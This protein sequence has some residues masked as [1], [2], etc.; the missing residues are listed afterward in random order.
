MAAAVACCRGE[1]PLTF[2]AAST[3][4]ALLFCTPPAVS[5]RAGF[6][7]LAG[8]PAHLLAGRPGPIVVTQLPGA[9]ATSG[10]RWVADRLGSARGWAQ[11][12]SLAVASA[13]GRC[14][15]VNY[16][17]TSAGHRATLP[18]HRHSQR[19][20][21][22]HRA[23]H[24]AIASSQSTQLPSQHRGRTA[25]ALPSH[26]A[27][28]QRLPLHCRSCRHSTEAALP[29]RLPCSDCRRYLVGKYS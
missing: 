3:R 23:G 16:E 5:L 21:S 12:P 27:H 11:L 8:T 25:I 4:H 6:F 19:R 15:S 1:V 9:R 7:Y 24:T 13:S 22:Q 28:C 14:L 17:L 18:S 10:L 26:R 29:L 2:D 20:L